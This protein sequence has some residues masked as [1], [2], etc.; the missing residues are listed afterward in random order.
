MT[1]EIRPQKNSDSNYVLGKIWKTSQKKKEGFASPMEFEALKPS[2][3]LKVHLRK[4]HFVWKNWALLSY[5]IV[6]ESA[7]RSQK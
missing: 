4:L 2:L 5:N 1:Q 7:Y 6:S 3:E